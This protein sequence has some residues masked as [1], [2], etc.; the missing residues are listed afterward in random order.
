MQ[1]ASNTPE[2]ILVRIKNKICL[3]MGIDTHKLKILIDRFLNINFK[4]VAPSK[5]HYDKV[6]ILN[7][8]SKNK[9]TIKVFFKFLKIIN[10]KHIKFNIVLTTF[11]N[12]E[13]SI[14]E[15]IDMFAYSEDS[16]EIENNRR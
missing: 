11:N 14:I 7:E 6:N 12:K 1:Q 5:R 2:G 10:I 8:F 3:S 15:D 16:S 13:I 4:D 9:M